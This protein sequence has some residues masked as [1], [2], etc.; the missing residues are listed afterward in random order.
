M[1]S[2]IL[3]GI[4]NVLRKPPLWDM[5][6]DQIK[7]MKQ[8]FKIDGSKVERELGITY[9]PVYDAIKEAIESFR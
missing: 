1:N 8:G 4:A 2:Y 7:L 5:S 6:V 9:T 3:T